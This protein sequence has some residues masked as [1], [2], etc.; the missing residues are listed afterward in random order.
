MNGR[1]ET[2]VFGRASNGCPGGRFFRKGFRIKPVHRKF[3]ARHVPTGRHVARGYRRRPL[4]EADAPNTC[5]GI[6]KAFGHPEIPADIGAGLGK[7]RRLKRR[8]ASGW[9]VPIARFPE[10][11]VWFDRITGWSGYE[12]SGNFFAK[13]KNFNDKWLIESA[14]VRSD[15]ARRFYNALT[16]ALRTLGIPKTANG[17]ENRH[18]HYRKK[19]RTFL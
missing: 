3:P 11:F 5:R 1:R 13:S 6:R 14:P 18:V 2:G 19:K 12:G 15:A 10:A 7:Q 17:K 4:F 9:T 16:G 8:S